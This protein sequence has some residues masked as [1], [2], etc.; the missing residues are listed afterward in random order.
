MF[1]LASSLAIFLH[2]LL[3]PSTCSAN[4]NAN[5]QGARYFLLCVVIASVVQDEEVVEWSEASALGWMAHPAEALVHVPVTMD[6]KAQ[7]GLCPSSHCR[8]GPQG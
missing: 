4:A 2:N 3:F 5:T 6:R 1:L 7:R 8:T